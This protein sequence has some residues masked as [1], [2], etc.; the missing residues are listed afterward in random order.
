[1]KD[2]EKDNRH[3]IS[4]IGGLA[5]FSLVVGFTIAQDQRLREELSRQI[6]AIL[7]IS[8]EAVKQA[9]QIV[10]RLNAISQ[11][12]RPN[13]TEAEWL[14]GPSRDMDSRGLEEYQEFWDDLG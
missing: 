14:S 7:D 6:K 3:L 8:Y 5:F 13:S 9:R 11:S 1:M 10:N 12:G 4:F 2:K